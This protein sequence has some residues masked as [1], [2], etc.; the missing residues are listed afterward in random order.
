MTEWSDGSETYT[1]LGETCYYSYGSGG[2]ASPPPA[3]G[4]GTGGPDQISGNATLYQA[5]NTGITNAQSKLGNTQCAAL[6]SNLTTT[7]PQAGGTSL[8]TILQQRGATDPINYLMNFVG[9]YS[10]QTKT[11][12]SGTAPCQVSS[13]YAWTNPGI[14]TVWV[15]DLF[16]QLN[17]TPGMAADIVIHELLHTLGLPEGG[18]N[19]W[20]NQQITNMVV[21]ACGQ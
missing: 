16:T 4:G 14:T 15:C 8:I 13:R 1:I 9:Y 2:G 12:A 7:S 19:Q 11:D 20:T 17:G 10:G 5:V 3:G 18:T 21:Q 6:F